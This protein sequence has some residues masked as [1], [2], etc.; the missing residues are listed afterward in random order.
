VPEHGHLAAVYA[1]DTETDK[2]SPDAAAGQRGVLKPDYF[3]GGA[4]L[5]STAPNYLRFAEMLRRRGEYQGTRVLGTRT[6][7]YM[8][9]NHLPGNGYRVSF[10]TPVAAHAPERGQGYGLGV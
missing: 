10:G 1:F 4:G 8:T 9:K 6:V 5:V 3:A 7:E 2:V